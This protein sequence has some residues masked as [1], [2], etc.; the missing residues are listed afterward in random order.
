M[1]TKASGELSGTSIILNPL[2]V[3]AVAIVGSYFGVM[4][5]NTA[6]SGNGLKYERSD[7]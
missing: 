1:L 3:S 7:N 5:R 4:P 6:M 2:S